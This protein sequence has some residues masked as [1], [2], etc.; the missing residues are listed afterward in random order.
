MN[1]WIKYL[2]IGWSIVS[3]GLV[4]LSFRVT[5]RSI[6][7]EKYFISLPESIQHKISRIITPRLPEGFI[8][9]M[10]NYKKEGFTDQEIF[11]YTL[12]KLAEMLSDAKITLTTK[13]FNTILKDVKELQIESQHKVKNPLE[14]YILFPL[15]AFLIWALPI[16]VFSLVG[17]VF[18]RK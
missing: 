3:V 4:V 8:L 7:E 2:I 15:Y 12:K 9:D 16:I 1:T 17:L 6:I 14:F 13:E 18:S 5:K 11:D 10:T